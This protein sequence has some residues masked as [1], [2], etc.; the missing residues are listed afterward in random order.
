M[1]RTKTLVS[2][3]LALLLSVSMIAGAVAEPLVKYE[4]PVT[5]V[6]GR[7][8]NAGGQFAPGEDSENNAW[9]QMLKDELNIIIDVK[10][11]FDVG[12]DDYDSTV[13]MRV[14]GQTMPDVFSIGETPKAMAL[15]YQLVEA[16]K[17]A[18]LT[19]IFNTEIGGKTQEYIQTQ[20][21][22]NIM[23]FMTV[24]GK[25]YGLNGGKEGYNTALL[26]IR[27]DWLDAVGME[28]PSTLE[29]LEAVALAFIEQKP[30]GNENTIGIPLNPAAPTA[31]FGQ[32][33]GILPVFNAV[34]SYPDIW[35]TDADGKAV[36]GGVQPETKEA[37]GILADWYQK[38]ILDKNL[39]TMKDGDEVRDTY[40]ATNGC[41]MV[42]NA[43]W[44]PWVQW[45]GLQD[46]SVKN[47]PTVEWIPVL[48]PLNK[49]GKFS[50]KNESIAPGGLVISA[51]FAHPEAVV[52][53][54]NLFH[55][56]DIFRNPA[57]EDI[58]QKYI[59][60]VEAI[61]S[62]RT[63]SP[64]PRAM[65][66]LQNRIL[67]AQNINDYKA[68]GVLTLD[69]RVA[70]DADYIQGA[71]NWLNANT[72][73]DWYANPDDTMSDEYMFQYVGHLAHD[74]VGNMYMEAE[75]AGIFEE[76]MPSFI[77]TVDAH[78]DYGAMLYD[79]QHT[80][81][82][83]IISGAQPLDYF[84]EFVAQWEKLGGTIVTEQVNA[85]FE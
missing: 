85:T 71:Y 41:G 63:N 3:C 75:A 79:L 51:D 77:G 26:W 72:M 19:E 80:A 34:G 32:W 28:A 81:F 65:V 43:W 24:D 14:A 67:T 60:P 23:Q 29:E 33:L 25:I 56:V 39:V 58:R 46:L 61:T 82:M 52:K 42:F 17:L 36:W 4:E 22:G 76:K 50:P 74:M 84:D 47:D 68:T 54:L 20:D 66:Q 15:F 53:A 8:N 73:A 83:Q 5:I 48:A 40:L 62:A 18:D 31:M 70:N 13:A 2:L 38:G 16:G 45:E 7:Q 27:K 11:G 35:V 1:R 64:F 10:N 12:G 9:T 49:E 21:M 6:V 69:P 78:I 55:E 44:D 59:V 57:Y 37:L 30:G